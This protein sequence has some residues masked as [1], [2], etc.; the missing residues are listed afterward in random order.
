MLAVG[1]L[2]ILN[3]FSGQA[4]NVVALHALGIDREQEDVACEG[5]LL[6]LPLRSRSRRRFTSLSV[7]PFLLS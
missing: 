4:E 5:N 1:E 7:R 2:S 6:W 3:V